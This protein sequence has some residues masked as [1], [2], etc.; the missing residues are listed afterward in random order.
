VTPKLNHFTE[1]RLY[2]NT[3]IRNTSMTVMSD[4]TRD[5]LLRILNVQFSDSALNMTLLQDREILS[6]GTVVLTQADAKPHVTEIHYLDE[7]KKPQTLS[8]PQT[9]D[10][11]PG[12]II[13]DFTYIIAWEA[14]N[15]SFVLILSKIL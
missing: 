11:K 6:Q 12:V 14:D 13:G 15:S 1:D 7:G 5:E 3:V 2:C 9:W 4:S 8:I 10:V